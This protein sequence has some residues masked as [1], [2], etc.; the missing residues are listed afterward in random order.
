[1]DTTRKLVGVFFKGHH[2]SKIQTDELAYN[3]VIRCFI[4]EI[5][6]SI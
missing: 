4:S 3:E 6:G 1:M 5:H 2:R